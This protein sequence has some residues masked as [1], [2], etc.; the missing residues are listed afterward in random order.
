MRKKMA[1]AMTITIMMARSAGLLKASIP[2]VCV[3]AVELDSGTLVVDDVATIWEDIAV[4]VGVLVDVA[5][6]RVEATCLI[7]VQSSLTPWPFLK[8]DSMDCAGIV[9]PLQAVWA[10]LWSAWSDCIQPAEHGLMAL[11]SE[12]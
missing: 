3:C 4:A 12:G 1:S 2:L 11:K 9:C 7:M 6:S 5:V 8:Y 10:S